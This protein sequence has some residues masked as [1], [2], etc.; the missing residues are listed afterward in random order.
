MYCTI[1]YIDVEDK[2]NF[3][4]ING[5]DWDDGNINKNWRSHLIT[6]K[7]AEEVFVNLPKVL[8]V[9]KKHLIVEERL[10][11]LGRTNKGRRLT[12]AFTIRNNKFRI[13]S[14]RDMNKKERRKYE[15]KIKKY[16]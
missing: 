11:I 5:F 8:L 6:N 16:T 14:A 2:H 15:E 9:D 10:I 3:T 7:E 4:N 12:I 1:K 13:I